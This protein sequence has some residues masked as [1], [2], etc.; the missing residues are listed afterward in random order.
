MKAMEAFFSSLIVE[1][2]K[3]QITNSSGKT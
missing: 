3:E 1:K 2:L